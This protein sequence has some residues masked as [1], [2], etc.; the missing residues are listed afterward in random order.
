[1]DK[2]IPPKMKIE[3]KKPSPKK[4]LVKNVILYGFL[5]LLGL[6]LFFAFSSGFPSEDRK[7]LT[8]ALELVEQEEV[9]NVTVSGD[10]LRLELRSGETVVSQ[11]EAERS[12]LEILEN[13]G[14]SPEKITGE[15]T[16]EP[17]ADFS[18]VDFLINVLPVVLMIGFFVMLF[19]RAGGTGGGPGGGFFSIG[20]SKATLFGKDQP[21]VSFDDAAGVDEA[22]KELREVVDF[23]KNPEKYEKLGAR[24]PK[25]V[26]LVGPAGTG[27]TL[28][29][30]AVASE[31]DVPF[32]SA[33]GSEFME[34]LVGVGSARV[35]DMFK[36][37][38]QNAP[39]LIFI[40]E[41]E[42]IG[43]HR[44]ASFMSQGEQEQTLN[45]I[46]TEMDGFEP[47]AGVVVLGATNKPE[48]L[49]PALVRPGRFDR[50]IVLTFPDIEGRKGIIKIHMKG[51]PFTDEVDV[52]E[53]ARRT[54]GFSGADIE[55]MLNEAAILAA[56]K[57]EENIS[58]EHLEEAATKVKLGPERKRLH[59]EE[60]R[61]LIA[62]HEAGHAVVAHLLE[63]MD[64]V[65]R[66]SIVS[67]GLSL[68]FTM[69]PPKVDRYNQTKNR[70]VAQ[71]T[72]LLGG[73]ASEELNLSEFSIGASS[74]IRQATH[75]AREM[76]TKYGMSE[77]GPIS[78]ESH[79]GEHES[80][81]YRSPLGKEIDYSDGVLSKV[82]KEV[83]KI[84]DS[85]YQQAKELVN[86]NKDS[87][88]KVAKELMEK[89]S[90]TG[91]EF[92]SLIDAN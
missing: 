41:I 28:L 27:K 79:L 39:S 86:N 65:H 18:W 15:I 30:R 48:M 61:Q 36:T 11:K 63:D 49:D 54:V 13:Q 72:A 71:I 75:L 38:K 32:F 81:P 2:K 3:L 26:L 29:A 22:K 77:L 21:Q 5:A 85:C 33:A 64:P 68:G 46:L 76:V 78:F 66:V 88:D 91:D 34:M 23:L 45:Q 40:D 25:G 80:W 43:R 55:N 73:R 87:L 9:K 17:P 6:G 69:I 31:A 14:I 52:E 89:E 67:R 59:S 42:T 58:P 47:N 12:F 24:I 35:R 19:R 20:K 57:G 4:N 53:L 62:Y 70:L 7:S 51:K 37:A 1:M 50:R 44:G 60:E 10:V 8:Q 16:V 90:L 84:V 92:R 83:Q 74:D 82:D 56:R